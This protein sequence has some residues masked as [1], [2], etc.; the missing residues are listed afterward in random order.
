[1]WVALLL[2]D[3]VA[4]TE[5]DGVAAVEIDVAAA[6]EQQP[7]PSAAKVAVIPSRT[8]HRASLR[9]VEDVADGL[10]GSCGAT[11]CAHR[12]AV[13]SLSS[14]QEHVGIVADRRVVGRRLRARR[15]GAPGCTRC[16]VMMMAR[17]VSFF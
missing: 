14:L 17:S 8:H 1:M 6:G 16:G 13:S 5:R 7:R 4:R 12:F 11:A 3:R 15:P 2:L 9:Q 10:Y